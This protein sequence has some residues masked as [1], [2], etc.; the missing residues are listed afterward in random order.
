MNATTETKGGLF[1]ALAALQADLPRIGKGNTADVTNAQGKKLYSYKFADLADV[2]QAIMPKLGKVGLAFTS[3]PT[4]VDGQFVLVYKLTHVS[5]ETDEGMYPLPANGTP[6]AIGGAITYARRYCLCAVT[7]IAPDGDDDDARAAEDNH[8]QSAA[9]AFERAAPAQQPRH[10]ERMASVPA[11]DPWYGAAPPDAD[12]AGGTEAKQDQPATTAPKASRPRVTRPEAAETDPVWLD[13][14]Y[15]EIA[16]I[17]TREDGV[18]AWASIAKAF[19]SNTCTAADRKTL[20]ATVAG[21]VSE[22]V[23]NEKSAA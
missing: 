17:K 5:G 2:S 21:N 18:K 8:R 22:V 7:G 6:Q 13:L 11:D 20:E 1:A 16:Q 3:K 10:A 14:M 15:Q 9:D 23:K 4:L 19:D 12:T